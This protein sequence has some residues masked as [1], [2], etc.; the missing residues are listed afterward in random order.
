[1][2]RIVV[3][4]AS[5]GSGSKG[6]GTLLAAGETL[7]LIDCGFTLKETEKRFL[8]LGIAPSDLSAI[9]V[10]HEHGDHANGVAALSR[11]YGVPVYMSHGTQLTG[12]CS[13]V[14]QAV[15]FDA[16][17][18]FS[19]DEIAVASIMVPHDARQPCQYVFKVG[20]LKLG[21]LTDVGHITPHIVESYQNCDYLILEFNHDRAMLQSGPYPPSLKRRV[22]GDL[23]HLN[24]Q[25]ASE[26][27]FHAEHPGLKRVL[28]AHISQQNNS[29]EAVESAI[30]EKLGPDFN[31]HQFATQE[32]GFDWIVLNSEPKAALIQRRTRKAVGA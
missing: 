24:N 32:A 1:L 25:Q 29:L 21:L 11:R 6:N 20:G 22:G 19:I 3:R 27:L 13:D 16:G 9:L 17:E 8:D 10:T 12:R 30:K 31:K 28:I 7:I 2:E 5:I 23:G 15:C 14:H 18:C 26:L 4:I